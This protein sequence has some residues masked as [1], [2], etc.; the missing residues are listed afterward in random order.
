MHHVTRH[1]ENKIKLLKTPAQALK[2]SST[3]QNI[4]YLAIIRSGMWIPE[5]PKMELSNY[6][7][8][9]DI[10][11]A[12]SEV[13]NNIRIEVYSISTVPSKSTGTQKSQFSYFPSVLSAFKIKPI[14]SDWSVVFQGFWQKILHQLLRKNSHIF[15]SLFSKAKEMTDKQ[16][17]G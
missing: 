11:C 16:I 15:Y 2:L 5:F 1:Q 12:Q 14:R 3:L 17:H 8:W 13:Q 7:M 4:H 6:S 10:I 9:P